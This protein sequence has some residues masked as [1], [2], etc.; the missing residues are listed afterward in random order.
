MDFLLQVLKI[1]IMI[2]IPVAT[3]VLTYYIKLYVGNLIKQ[4]TQ[5]EIAEILDQ[6]LQVIMDSVNYVQQTYV[7]TLKKHDKFTEEAH[8]EAFNAA[9]ERAIELMNEEMKKVIVDAYGNLDLYVDT[10]IESIINQNKKGSN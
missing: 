10:M 4:N 3:S 7:D 9:K 5:G 2:L 6:G 8:M 1:V